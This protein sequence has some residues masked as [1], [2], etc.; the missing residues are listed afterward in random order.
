MTN[1]PARLLDVVKGRSSQALQS[2]LNQRDHSFRDRIEVVSMDGFAGYARAA[3]AAVPKATRVMD[4][5]HVVRLAGD[6]V[7]KC[8]QRIQI[9]TTG[10]RG[11]R[12]DPLYKNRK[13]ML[14]RDSLLT[15][16]Q[17]ARLDDLWAFDE[18]YQPLHQAYLVYQRVFDAYEMKNRRQAKKAMSH[19]IDQLR[20][21]KGTAHKEI[22][23]LGRSLHKRRRDI[24]AFF[25]RGVSNG[26]VEAI[27]GRLEHLRGIALGFKNLNHYILRCLIHSGGLTNKINAL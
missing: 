10:R 23:Q 1:K 8:R 26:P 11:R 4:P 2:W 14:T 19:L 9:E 24:L 12:E 18:G 20:V 17:K 13:T 3:E 6:K 7:T 5:F 22:A 21:M 27:N 16:E 25:D 15:E